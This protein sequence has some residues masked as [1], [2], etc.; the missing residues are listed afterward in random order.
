[1]TTSPQSLSNDELKL[2]LERLVHH[3]R[4]L[5]AVILEHI[6]EV[7]RRELHLHWGFES[8]YAYLTRGLGYS[9]SA[10]YRR[11]QAA[12]V[13]RQIPEIQTKIEQGDLN[14]SQITMVQS[15]VRAQAAQS[16]V[17]G[18]GTQPRLEVKKELLEAISCKNKADT[19][20]LIDQ[21]LGC[22]PQPQA[23]EIHKKDDSVQLTLQIPAELY[24]KLLKIK[25]LYSHLRPGASWVELLELMATDVIQKRDPNR[26]IR[27]PKGQ[28]NKQTQVEKDVMPLMQKRTHPDREGESLVPKQMPVEGKAAPI[29]AMH[30]SADREPLPMMEKQSSAHLE[31]APILEKKS[32]NRIEAIPRSLKRL[33]FQ[34]AHSQCQYPTPRGLCGSRHQLEMDHIQPVFAG[35][36]ND[37]D[38]LR[39]VCRAHN[40]Y[41]YKHGR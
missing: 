2:R 16:G 29:L 18:Q 32:S 40:Q 30:A 35:G 1:M 10:A 15:A 36:T 5:T 38:N 4:K 39:L 9:E 26:E 17:R 37:P 22:K 8:M 14:L 27:K 13:V 34:K 6:N 19:Q 24:Q 20:K 31:A 12:R 33:V 21:H 3:E 11:L 7:E 23:Q 25:S 41:R 28:L